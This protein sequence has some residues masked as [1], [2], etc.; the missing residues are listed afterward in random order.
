MESNYRQAILTVANRSNK[1]WVIIFLTLAIISIGGVL[2]L[3]LPKVE[4]KI[5]PTKQLAEIKITVKLDL[6]ANKVIPEL[7]VVPA[8]ISGEKVSTVL[9]SSQYRSFSYQGQLIS[10]KV[11]DYNE[12]LNYHLAKLI[13]VGYSVLGSNLQSNLT[14]PEVSE[15]GRQFSWQVSLSQ[16]I[17]KDIPLDL[18]QSEIKS[19]SISN[20]KDWLL[21]QSGVEN[22]EVYKKYSFLANISKILFHNNQRYL[23]TL[24]R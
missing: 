24:D 9:K 7:G 20:A 3:I 11:A 21:S 22:V 15:S 12:L 1:R 14:L 16:E 10:Y 23:V 17:I 19:K 18:W 6:D 4:F 5:K 2:V 13:P 8:F